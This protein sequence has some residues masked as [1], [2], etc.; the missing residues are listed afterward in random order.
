LPSPQAA[1]SG[2]A[3]VLPVLRSLGANFDFENK[4]GKYV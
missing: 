3:D 2:H 4:V 1:L